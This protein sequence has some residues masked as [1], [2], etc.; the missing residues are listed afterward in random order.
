MFFANAD[1][2]AGG[3]KKIQVRKRDKKRYRARHFNFPECTGF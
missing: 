1:D 3:A 2:R